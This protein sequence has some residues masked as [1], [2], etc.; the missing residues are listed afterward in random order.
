MDRDGQNVRRITENP[1]I[2][3]WGAIWHKNGQRLIFISDL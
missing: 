3:D 1:Q 2:S